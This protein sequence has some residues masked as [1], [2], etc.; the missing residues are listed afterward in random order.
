MTPMP[1]AAGCH[2]ADAAALEELGV[3]GLIIP[4]IALAGGDPGS[5]LPGIER[6][7]DRWLS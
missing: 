3:D 7:A 4:G 5:V 6:F 2:A 1:V